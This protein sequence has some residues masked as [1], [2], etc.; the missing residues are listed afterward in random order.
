M[1]PE[2]N[3]LDIRIRL[4][5]VLTFKHQPIFSFD[6]RKI[7]PESDIWERNIMIISVK[8]ERNIDKSSAYLLLHISKIRGT[9]PFY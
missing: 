3:L 4:T 6:I 8:Y 1:H 2:E 7:D 9:G 5:K